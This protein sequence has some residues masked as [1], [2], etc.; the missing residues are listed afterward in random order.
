MSRW[1]PTTMNASYWSAQPRYGLLLAE[2][3]HLLTRGTGYRLHRSDLLIRFD[4]LKHHHQS[5]IFK[6]LPEV[7][8]CCVEKPSR[9]NHPGKEMND[10]ESVLSLIS[11]KL[12]YV[13]RWP[14]RRE[15]GEESIRSWH[16]LNTMRPGSLSPRQLRPLLRF[17]LIY[18]G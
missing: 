17:C 12:N 13:R 16:W 4:L 5:S 9:E 1:P 14:V 8:L 7:I 6:F 10:G 2:S 11:S 15:R 3:W 18:R